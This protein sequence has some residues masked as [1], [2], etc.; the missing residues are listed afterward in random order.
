MKL[1]ILGFD[2]NTLAEKVLFYPH[3]DD[4]YLT[5]MDISFSGDYAASVG[6]RN[7]INIWNTKTRRVLK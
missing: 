4:D 2:E 5:S 6:N 3:F 7:I 1:A